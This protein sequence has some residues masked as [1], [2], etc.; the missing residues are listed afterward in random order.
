MRSNT[1]ALTLFSFLILKACKADDET[2]PEDISNEEKATVYPND[3]NAENFYG[4][5]LFG[6]DGCVDKDKAWRGNLQEAYDDAH[7]LIADKS[8]KETINWQEAA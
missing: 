5:K 7:K 6:F 1:V 2:Q 4:T 3:V 8:V